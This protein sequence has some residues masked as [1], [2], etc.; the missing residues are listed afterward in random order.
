M[1]RG[2]TFNRRQRLKVW[3]EPRLIKLRRWWGKSLEQPRQP[4]KGVVTFASRLRIKHTKANG[5]VVDHGVV[6]EKMFTTA[7]VNYMVDSFQDSTTYPLDDFKFH[8]SG[9][10]VGAEAVGDTILGTEV[11]SRAT[12]TQIEGASANI[13]KSVGEVTYTGTHAIT[14]HG[15]FSASTGATLLDRS[16]F[17]AINVVASD[18]IEFTY[19]LTCTAGG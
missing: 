7:A 5:E 19:E 2:R 18:K 11:E 4:L 15:L 12:G 3:L 1:T 14:E 13:Y 10:G 9:T 6:S 16:V 8:G 17:S